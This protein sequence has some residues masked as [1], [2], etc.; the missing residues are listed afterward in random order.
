MKKLHVVNVRTLAEFACM[1]GSLRPGAAPSRMREGR[2]GHAALQ[3]LLGPQWQIEAPV[4]CD[5]EFDEIILRIQGRADAFCLNGDQACVSEIKT[6]RRDLKYIS[7]DDYPVHWAQA[8]I[9]GWLF[10]RNYR[11]LTVAL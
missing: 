11:K 5:L 4:S 9:Y 2:E 7:S 3:D 8:E 10:C 6:T 1:S